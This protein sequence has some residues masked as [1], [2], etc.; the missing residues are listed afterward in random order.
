MAAEDCKPHKSLR[1]TIKVFLRTEEKKREALRVKDIKNTPPAT[2]AT[3]DTPTE[4]PAASALPLESATTLTLDA[5]DVTPQP[6][7]SVTPITGNHSGQ[8]PTAESLPA[9]LL[10]NPQ[11]ANPQSSTEVTSPFSLL[12]NHAY[13]V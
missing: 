9:E 11:Q 3:P 7:S 12:L 6:P 8:V 10:A 4:L 2:P 13:H 1:T 5:K